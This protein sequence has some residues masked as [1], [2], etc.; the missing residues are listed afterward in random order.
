MQRQRNAGLVAE[1][2]LLLPHVSQALVRIGGLVPDDGHAAALAMLH[3]RITPTGGNALERR[4]VG[5]RRIADADELSVADNVIDERR[6]RHIVKAR[7]L[8][9]A[10][11]LIA[12]LATVPCLDYR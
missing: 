6:G 11:V 3:D 5:L 7:A 8:G 2:S 12:E 1:T 9:V 10:H 4:Q